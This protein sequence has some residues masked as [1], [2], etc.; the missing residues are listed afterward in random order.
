MFL[1]L[2][3]LINNRLAVLLQLCIVTF[4]DWCKALMA[5]PTIGGLNGQT[6]QIAQKKLFCKST[7]SVCCSLCIAGLGSVSDF[8]TADS[9][10]YVST[11]PA[12]FVIQFFRHAY[13]TPTC[14]PAYFAMTLS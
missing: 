2:V 3:V 10:Q 14:L 13:E 12:P 1:D 11:Q 4:D 5:R 6:L 8:F 7:P 9:V